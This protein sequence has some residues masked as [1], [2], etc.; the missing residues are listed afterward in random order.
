MQQH[1][2]KRC[3]IACR[4]RTPH[5]TIEG[6]YKGVC[7]SKAAENYPP[8][9]ARSLYR[10]FLNSTFHALVGLD[11]L[12][13]APTQHKHVLQYLRQLHVALGHASKASMAQVL[14]EA[15][16]ND[17]LVK[18]ASEY[19]CPLCDAQTGP[20]PVPKVAIKQSTAINDAF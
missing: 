15:G 11:E 4:T 5:D 2:P 18:A 6:S 3:S 12:P 17:W 7:V 13:S 20:K 10:C 14:K 19:T 9:F 8:R 16:A 1:F